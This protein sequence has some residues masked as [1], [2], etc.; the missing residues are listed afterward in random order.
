VQL[1][2]YA[3][4]ARAIVCVL[5][6]CVF[7]ALVPDVGA[8]QS[9]LIGTWK[10][11]VAKSTFSPGPP[12][13]SSTI[14]YEAIGQG[15]RNT[16]ESVDA[17]GKTLRGTFTVVEDGKYYPVT[18]V[19]DFDS[20]AYKRIDAN[21]LENTRMKAGRVVQSGRRVL[22]P[23]G[24]TLTFTATGVNANGQQI[25]DVAVYERQ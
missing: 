25:N 17:S 4:L 3:P 24:R 20:S 9:A 12:F 13:R 2:I 11:N 22:S 8:A 5:A 19:P 10:L 6:A 15:L 18:G 23:D 16:F 14:T 1:T 7:A 21:T